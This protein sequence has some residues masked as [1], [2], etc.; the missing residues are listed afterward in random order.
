MQCASLDDWL[1]QLFSNVVA[2]YG[3]PL[4]RIDHLAER[5]E[6]RP[7]APRVIVVTGTNG[8]GST[9][10]LLESIYLH[11][12]YSV[13]AITSP[14]VM[15]F[16]ERLTVNGEQVAASDV[17]AAFRYVDG[18][19]DRSQTNTFDFMYLSL[20]WC[21]KQFAPQIAII[22]AGIGG[23]YDVS[24]LFD[25]D[26]AVI[27]TVALDH[28]DLLGDT[29]EQIAA[30]KV[31]LA[32]SGR[33]LICGDPL[34]PLTI[35]EEVSRIGAKLYQL[36]SNNN[37]FGY[38]INATDWQWHG[39]DRQYAALP[40]PTIKLQNAA[41]SLM[42]VTALQ[43]Q[44]P[45]SEQAI[46]Q[47]LQQ[48]K[49]IG[50]FEIDRR[51]HCP[52]IFDVAHNPQACQW[53]NEQL[54]QQVHTGRTLMVFALAATKQLVPAL[55]ALR[56]SANIWW[57]AP[58]AQRRSHCAAEIKQEL[59]ALGIKNC[60]TDSSLAGALQAALELAECNDRIVVCGSFCAVQ[61]AMQFLG[62]WID[63]K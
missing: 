63:G 55:A 13:A 50:R 1:T 4:S 24:N 48:V 14:H 3:G 2:R 54:Q 6:L 58:L 29:R 41:T 46:R 36:Y 26:A 57:V 38:S 40:L 44:L 20:L 51:A 31:Q 53:L 30:N 27:T 43:P 12:G 25:A 21:L 49:M 11:A 52:V 5:L 16:T 15:Q 23:L 28:T 10:R 56:D 7:L 35:A 18:L 39:P 37:G 42:V 60:Y 22:E 33:P 8:K 62:G 19:C 47:G 59:A 17:V 32:R 61:E 34:P 45:V 9:V